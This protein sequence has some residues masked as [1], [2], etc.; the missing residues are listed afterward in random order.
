MS[1]RKGKGKIHFK[2]ANGVIEINPDVGA[3]DRGI[4]RR[5]VTLPS[6]FERLHKLHGVSLLINRGNG[7][8]SRT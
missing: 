8:V 2:L 4:T 5:N 1:R 6:D 3:R 7:I